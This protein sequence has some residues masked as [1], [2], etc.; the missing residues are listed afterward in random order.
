MCSSVALY[1]TSHQKNLL[2]PER[3]QPVGLTTPLPLF[4]FMPLSLILTKPV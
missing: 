1:P 2:H 4:N 3:V